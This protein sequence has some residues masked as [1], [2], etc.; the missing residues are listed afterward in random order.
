M[1]HTQW[2]QGSNRKDPEW[3]ADGPIAEGIHPKVWTILSYTVTY[4]EVSLSWATEFIFSLSNK[5]YF[6]ATWRTLEI[7][8]PQVQVLDFST[9]RDDIIIRKRARLYWE[10]IWGMKNVKINL[11]GKLSGI[12]YYCK[13]QW[14]QWSLV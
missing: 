9:I 3:A 5:N 1:F 12:F 7:V 11:L 13:C 2:N 4:L 6:K 14:D 8:H 10:V